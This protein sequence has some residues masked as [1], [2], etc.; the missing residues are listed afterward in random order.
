MI[1]ILTIEDKTEWVGYVERSAET[2]FYQT[3]H[4]HSLNN[5]GTALLFV[6]EEGYDFIAI[7]LIKRAIPESTYFDLTSVYGYSGPLSNNKMGAIDSRLKANFKDAFNDFL[8]EGKY[9]SV[10]SRMNPFYE[11]Q[12][13]LDELGS[14]HENGQVVVMDLRGSIEDQRRRYKET[15]LASV[16]KAV[17][18]GYIIKEEN[19][20]DAIKVFKEIYDENMSRVGASDAY[21]FD[22][23][24]Y[25]EMLNTT[26]YDARLFMAYKD[27]VVA[28]S[29]IVVF[30]NTFI[31]SYLIG[32]RAEYLRDSPAKFMADAIGQIGREC[33]KCYF[34]LGGGVGFQRD[35]LFEWKKAFSDIIFDFK[36]LRHIANPTV[37]Q[38]LLD[39]KGIDKDTNV[40]FFPLYRLA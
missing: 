37:Y 35:S 11:Q 19:G 28:C 39:Q 5:N 3:W 32:T 15:T 8:S 36:S 25:A 4:Y 10:F 21:L 17:K 14:V 30:A 38:Q 2:D 16:K 18:N 31:Q 7:P 13:L 9:V 29:T 26:E 12:L 40:D 23:S 33:G 27:N 34:N 1:R 20:P 6:Y 22:E 24:H